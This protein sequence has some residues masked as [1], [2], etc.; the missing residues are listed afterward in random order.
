MA[1][2]KVLVVEDNPLVVRLNEALL[3]AGDYDVITAM[4]GQS[5]I[6]MAVKERPDV[7][8]LDIILPKMHGFEVCKELRKREDTKHIPI[9]IVS[10][11]GLEEVAER[12]PDLGV[13]GVITKPYDLNKLDEAIKKALKGK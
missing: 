3:K 8:L 7:I 12:E 13:N 1:R 9:V 2:I 11:T 6:D 4:D 10:G 5:G